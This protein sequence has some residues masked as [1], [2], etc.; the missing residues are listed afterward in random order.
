MHTLRPGQGLVVY[1]VS[2][3]DRGYINEMASMPPVFLHCTFGAQLPNAPLS[4]HLNIN[5]YHLW[6]PWES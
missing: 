1:Q 4:K 3:T 5:F 2:A 6:L